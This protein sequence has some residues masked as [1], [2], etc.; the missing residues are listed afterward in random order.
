MSLTDVRYYDKIRQFYPATLGV[1]GES[2]LLL[3]AIFL[4][5]FGNVPSV[6]NIWFFILLINLTIFCP[7]D[8]P[9]LLLSITYFD[10]LFCP[11]DWSSLLYA[12][13]F[14]GVL[15]VMILHVLILWLLLLN[16]ALL[17][18]FGSTLYIGEVIYNCYSL[19]GCLSLLFS[20]ILYTDQV[21]VN[22]CCL[23]VRNTPRSVGVILCSDRPWYIIEVVDN[24]CCWSVLDT[25]TSVIVILCL[26]RPWYIFQVLIILTGGLLVICQCQFVC[27]CV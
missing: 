19:C 15:T 13:I 5:D 4:L 27:Y 21:T 7:F 18:C 8:W 9:S 23:S 24:S 26:D 14:V 20:G 3:S 17:L 1:L 12:F 16:A 22:C 2:I 25:P 6:W 10:N 11:S